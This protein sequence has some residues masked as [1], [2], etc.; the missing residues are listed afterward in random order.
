MTLDQRTRTH[1]KAI[2]EEITPMTSDANNP[3]AQAF[4]TGLIAG[5]GAAAQVA[6]GTSAEDAMEGILTNLQASIGRAYLDGSLT[7]QPPTA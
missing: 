1:L 5:I 3:T 6:A 7:G 4:V 2:V